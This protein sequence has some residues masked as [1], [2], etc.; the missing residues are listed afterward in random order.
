MLLFPRIAVPPP[1]AANVHDAIENRLAVAVGLRYADLFGPVL[2][3]RD[4]L[5]IDLRGTGRWAAIDCSQAAGLSAK[6][7][8]RVV[9]RMMPIFGVCMPA[10][11]G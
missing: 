7:P 1:S 8:S 4:L 9:E 2:D 6:R 5:T 3:T 11:A 10:L